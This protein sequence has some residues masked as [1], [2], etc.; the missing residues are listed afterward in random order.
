MYA[1]LKK[2]SKDSTSSDHLPLP[3]Y[4]DE[5]CS[6]TQR[7]LEEEEE[8]CYID[9]PPRRPFSFFRWQSLCFHFLLA[10][11]YGAAFLIATSK[12]REWPVSKPAHLI[13]SPLHEAI[14]MERK[15]VY[16]AIDSKNPFKGAPSEELDHAWHQLF[17]NSNIRV[18]AEDLARI[19]RTSV[20]INDEKGGYYAIPDV[21]HQLHCLKF[22]RQVVYQNYYHIGKP[23]T[24]VHIEHCVDNLRQNI[25]CKA[26][27]ALLTFTWDPNDRAPK[28]N[29]VVDH[30][31]A[32]WDMVDNW[33]KEHA[34]DI[35]DE[36]TLVHPT[37]GPSF[38]EKEYKATGKIPG[39]PDF[40][41]NEYHGGEMHHHHDGA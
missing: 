2:S 23:T 31:C 35:F 29:F 15:T 3:D 34:F 37:L 5:H 13:D 8:A 12:S 4:H 27:V 16:A 36:T 1:A 24:P 22:L 20:P 9:R 19:N 40:H 11:L 39:H 30:E 10:S 32:N 21:Y 26:D 41:P 18:T 28:P 33:A 6:K 7:L 25:M 38:P 14:H 17:V